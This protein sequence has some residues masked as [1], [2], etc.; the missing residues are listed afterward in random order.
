[1]KK[2]LLLSALLIF[3]CSSDDSDN[4]NSY[5]PNSEIRIAKLG[6]HS[7]QS[8]VGS[9]DIVSDSI[10]MNYNSQGFSYMRRHYSRNCYQ[11]DW[12]FV[13]Y[14][15]SEEENIEIIDNNLIGD[16]H[17]VADNPEDNYG[18][19]RQIS[20]N[21]DGNISYIPH[22]SQEDGYMSF[23]FEYNNGYVAQMVVN[24]IDSFYSAGYIE[25]TYTYNWQNGNLQ[26]ISSVSNNSTRSVSYQY[27][28]ITNNAKLFSGVVYRGF[29]EPFNP[30]ESNFCG[31]T[32]E[33]LPSLISYT[34]TESDDLWS[35]SNTKTYVFDYIL[36]NDGYVNFIVISANYINTNGEGGDAQW[37][38]EIE[39]T[40]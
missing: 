16:Y 11:N 22:A 14:D 17:Y 23:S 10:I 35:S 34:D 28:D 38:L 24:E 26:E 32:S 6:L 30:L 31:S 33:K 18:L 8:C 4:D 25:S 5:N 9:A 13:D 39:Y 36:D 19:V 40:N 37:T 12:S 20:L 2:L 29:S 3:A 15:G 21:S 7:I 27:T 1:M